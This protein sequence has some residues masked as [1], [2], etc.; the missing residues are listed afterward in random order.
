[1]AKSS[2]IA[3]GRGAEVVVLRPKLRS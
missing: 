3:I 2:K 1:M